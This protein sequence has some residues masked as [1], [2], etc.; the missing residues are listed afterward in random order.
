[1]PITAITSWI[2][3]LALVGTPFFSGFY[4]KDAIIEA[5]GESHRWGATYAYW[6]VLGG[7]FVTSLYTFRMIFMTF[8]G[9][10]RFRHAEEAHTSKGD[11]TVGHEE[12]DHGHGHGGEPHESPWVV[13]VPL[14]LLAIPS[15]LI[16]FF[17]VSQVLF[18]SYFG[19][20]IHVLEQNDV[21]GEIGRE[22]HGP[23]AFALHGFV[24]PPFWL[25]LAGFV[26]AW[27]FFLKQPSLADSVARTFGWLRGIL[28]NKYYF[29]WF[30]EKVIAALT[31]GIG[32]GLWKAG[33]QALIDGAVVNGSAAAVG[34]FGSIIRRVQNGYLYSY[35][36]WMVIGL[37]VLLG[38]FLVHVQ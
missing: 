23:V 6:C 22:F 20:A 26:T 8:H 12:E 16:G 28:I 35:A 10:E 31:R 7:V 9:P 32:F 15:V 38:W 37:A 33:D 11:K 13:T 21:V 18:G 30:N 17:T 34:W 36:F 4:S 3:A 27:V 25:A 5:V 19:D 24:S 14:V 29:D 2:G 1:M